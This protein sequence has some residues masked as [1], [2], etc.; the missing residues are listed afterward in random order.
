MGFQIDMSPLERSSMNVGRSLMDIGQQVGSAFQR[1]NQQEQQQQEQEGIDSLVRKSLAGDQASLEELMVKSPQAARMAAEHLQSQQAGQQQQEEYFKSQM[2][3]DTADF[4]EQMHLAPPEQQGAM[5][6]AG[7]GDERFDIDEEDRPYFMDANARKALISQVKGKD[8]A[9]NFFGQPDGSIKQQELDIKQEANDIRRLESKERSLDRQLSRETNELKRQQLESKLVDTKKD[10][11]N[12]INTVKIEGEKAI[13]EI[14]DSISVAKEIREHEGLDAAVG[15]TSIF[16]T[17]P[18]SDAAN[19]ESKLEQFKSKQFLTNIQK[20][21]GMGSLSESEGK[22]IA[23]A[24]G[25]LDLSMSEK[26]FRREMDIIINGLKKAKE[27]TN[28]KYGKLR[29]S[30]N[31]VDNQDQ[32]ALEWANANPNDPRA[33]QILNKLKG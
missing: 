15:G 4:V 27:F 18:G 24:A 30:K 11:K 5:F 13:V 17:I 14:N 9:E 21:K 2:A 23:A 22:K 26:A 3:Q 7:V 8:Y 32:Q 10:K 31:V 6:T 12:K 19:F 25:A 29:A 1:S 20:M 33:E 28:K 16:P